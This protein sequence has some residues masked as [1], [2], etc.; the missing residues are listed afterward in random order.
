MVLINNQEG[1]YQAHITS[2]VPAASGHDYVQGLLAQVP[3][4]ELQIVYV[5]DIPAFF[6]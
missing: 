5:Q 3:A 2:D 4:E 6:F 1:V